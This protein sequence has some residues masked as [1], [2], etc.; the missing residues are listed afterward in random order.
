MALE[1]KLYKTLMAVALAGVITAQKEKQKEMRT[2]TGS[3]LF[4][5][6]MGVCTLHSAGARVEQIKDADI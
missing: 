1:L 4:L 5:I 3:G 6:Q 2:F